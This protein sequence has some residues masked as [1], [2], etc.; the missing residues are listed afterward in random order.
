MGLNY[1]HS[2]GFSHRD[3]KAENILL[4]E[5][6]NVKIV[7][8]GFALPL[9][10]RDGSGFMKSYVGTRSYMAPELFADIRN[11]KGQ[12]VDL[13]AVGVVLFIMYAKCHP[14]S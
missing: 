10:G 4:D 12:D 9:K 13:F 2:E 1:L 14:F 7:D 6:F 3:L 11:Y 5:D 8:F